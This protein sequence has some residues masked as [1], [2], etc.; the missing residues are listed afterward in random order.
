MLEWIFKFF[1]SE[2]NIRYLF[3]LA[4]WETTKQTQERIQREQEQEAE[5][6]QREQEAKERIK[7]EQSK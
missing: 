7:L 3:A 4:G 5:R 6:I 1:L 2:D